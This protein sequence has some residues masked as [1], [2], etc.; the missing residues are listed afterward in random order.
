MSL[1]L[2]Q[3]E[4]EDGVCEVA[5]GFGDLA[6]DRA[7]IVGVLGYGEGAMPEHFGELL[8]TA[9]TEAARRCLPRAGYRL[10]EAGRAEGRLD[11][12]CVGGTVFSTQKIVA[13]ALGRAER[14]AAFACTIGP[15]LEEWGREVMKEDPALG[16]IADAVGSAVAEA[17]ADR[18]HDHIEFAMAQRGWRITNRYSPGYCGWSV[19]EQHALFALLPPA[20][21]GITLGESALMQPVKSVSG[22]VGVGPEVKHSDYLCDVC[23][24]RDCTYRRYHERR[25]PA[26]VP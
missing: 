15:G 25:K 2:P 9:L 16:F 23:N 24:V 20:F 19:A 4:R 14:A 7:G 5:V 3:T 18:L 17:L 11:A 6:V 13:G 12:L 8:D 26:V 1:A 10:V 21:C 22:I